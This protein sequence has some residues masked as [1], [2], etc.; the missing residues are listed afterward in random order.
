MANIPCELLWI[1][2]CLCLSC[3][4]TSCVY[5]VNCMLYQSWLSLTSHIAS[6][7]MIRQELR[8]DLFKCLH[9][10]VGGMYGQYGYCR[11]R[12]DW[13]SKLYMHM[14]L[15]WSYKQ[16]QKQGTRETYSNL[17]RPI[18]FTQSPE[19]VDYHE[20][21]WQGFSLLIFRAKVIPLVQSSSPVQC[22]SPLISDSRVQ[23]GLK[24]IH[25]S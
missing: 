21:C 5:S 8:A 25:F 3:L 13:I 14:H 20:K 18:L 22:S 23:A 10:E 17:P 12:T 1:C 4:P 19:C 11:V 24:G 2:S 7:H 9:V 6:E 16:Q 15:T